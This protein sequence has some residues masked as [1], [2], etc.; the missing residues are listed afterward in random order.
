MTDWISVEVYY[1]DDLDRVLR[2]VVVPTRDE[3]MRTGAATCWFFLR[4]WDG[5]NHLRLRIRPNHGQA[6]AVRSMLRQALDRFL[7]DEPSPDT[8]T[9]AMYRKLSSVLGT[10]EQLT[11][12]S[13]VLHPNNSYEFVAY[14][15]EIQR[16]GQGRSL[17]AA[18]QHFQQA[19][20]IALAVVHRNEP[21]E[22]RLTRCFTFLLTAWLVVLDEP[23]ALGSLADA[24][25]GAWA[26]RFGREATAAGS[27]SWQHRYGLLRE[28]LLRRAAEL[29]IAVGQPAADRVV[30]PLTD[31]WLASVRSLQ[32]K[33]LPD[34]RSGD[35]RPAIRAGWESALTAS[36]AELSCL[37]ALDLCA[38]LMF[39]RLGLTSRDEAFVRFLAASVAGDLADRLPEVC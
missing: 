18:E 31:A 23:A 3:L 38:H 14:R 16:Y 27:A 6:D 34:L 33:W 13:D 37:A 9:A 1:H 8:M 2:G 25:F 17:L 20:E 35:F 28:S 29:S 22:R 7:V 12:Y 32:T 30:D 11:G 21:R 36:T 5:G 24:L 10:A 39:N 15:P 4:Y 19:S 26:K